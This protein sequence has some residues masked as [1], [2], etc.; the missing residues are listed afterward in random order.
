MLY[1]IAAL[2]QRIYH[3][4]AYLGIIALVSLAIEYIVGLLNTFVIV[5]QDEIIRVLLQVVRG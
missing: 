1:V 4:N 2:N 5:Y 3:L